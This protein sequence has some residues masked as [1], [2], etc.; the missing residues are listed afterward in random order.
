MSNEIEK[1]TNGR[2]YSIQELMDLWGVKH[3]TIAGRLRRVAKKENK[4]IQIKT[5]VKDGHVF[6]KYRLANKPYTEEHECCDP[7]QKSKI[8]WKQIT[9]YGASMGNVSYDMLCKL[10][11]L[12]DEY[13]KISGLSEIDGI[14][15]PKRVLYN[16]EI[17]GFVFHRRNSK[18][19]R[20]IK[21]IDFKPKKGSEKADVE[22][23]SSMKLINEVFR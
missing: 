2:F 6:I 4:R 14:K 8:T 3:N 1:L 13:Y 9:E 12:K 23:P 18:Q 5:F 11:E 17:A 20:E 16:L 22:Q 10:F 7:F 15:N 19:N 21:L